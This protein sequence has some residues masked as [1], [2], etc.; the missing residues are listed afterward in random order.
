MTEGGEPRSIWARLP[1][2]L[3]WVVGAAVAIAGAIT[4]KGIGDRFPLDKR[5]PFWIAGTAIIFVGLWILSVGSKARHDGESKEAPR[6][7]N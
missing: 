7:K 6:K 1:R 3:Y 5:L 2:W 4:A